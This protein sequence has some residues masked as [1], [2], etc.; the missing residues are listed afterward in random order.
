MRIL[1]GVFNGKLDSEVRT[2]TTKYMY[3]QYNIPQVYPDLTSESNSKALPLYFR[4]IPIQPTFL[5]HPPPSPFFKPENTPTNEDRLYGDADDDDEYEYE[6]KDEERFT[7]NARED[8]GASIDYY[9]NWIM[10]NMG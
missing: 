3:I 2:Q 1:D 4:P 7:R 9:N 10:G 8:N 6:N 5:T